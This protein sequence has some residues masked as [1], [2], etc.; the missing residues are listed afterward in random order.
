MNM[1]MK[2]EAACTK[3]PNPCQVPS[4]GQR[5][6]SRK[7]ALCKGFDDDDDRDLTKVEIPGVGKG[8]RL[9]NSHST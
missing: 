4:K 1:Y 8:L 5:S 3:L 9:I 6:P 7:S 2:V